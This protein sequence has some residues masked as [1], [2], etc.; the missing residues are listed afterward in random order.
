MAP[1]KEKLYKLSLCYETR[2]QVSGEVARFF[3]AKGYDFL[4]PKNWSM[5]A[6]G[7]QLGV[8]DDL[9]KETANFIGVKQSQKATSNAVLFAE[10]IN[11]LRT[12]S[13][14]KFRLSSQLENDLLDFQNRDS[15]ALVQQILKLTGYYSGSIDGKWG[16]A[17]N[18]AM[19]NFMV[20]KGYVYENEDNW[21]MELQVELLTF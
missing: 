3:E 19:K 6:R 11:E 12:L 14:S 18:Q 7:I 10:D 15:A 13:F 9:L 5:E 20:E 1:S 16:P 17:S 2:K 8:E 4:V 21:S